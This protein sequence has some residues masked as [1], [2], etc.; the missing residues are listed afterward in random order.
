MI[1]CFGMKR[2]Y[3]LFSFLVGMITIGYFD[4]WQGMILSAV[5]FMIPIVHRI[6]KKQMAALILLFILG[7]GYF[8]LYNHII[9]N[10]TEN[11][12][13]NSKNTVLKV[14]SQPEE[15]S[16]G[17]TSYTCKMVGKPFKIKLYIRGKVS[18]ISYF[19]TVNVENFT[20]YSA[21]QD[22]YSEYLKSNSVYGNIT[23]DRQQ[24]SIIK[25]AH[26]WN[27]QV[28]FFRWKAHLL[29]VLKTHFSGD[30]YQL[31]SGIL[32]GDKSEQTDSFQHM[33]SASGVS[34]VVV[35]SGLHFGLWILMLSR[36]LLRLRLSLQK[37]SV[38]LIV[39]TLF[40]ALFMGW[41][42]SIIRVSVMLII[43]YLCDIYL[44]NH[45]DKIVI[46]ILAAFVP[47]ICNPNI[48]FS[49]SFIL[50]YGAVLGILLFSDKIAEILKKIKISFPSVNG[51]ISASISAQ[52][53]VFPFLI[54]YFN[55]FS[56]VFI[57][58]NLLLCL[59]LPFFMGYGIVFLF[60]TMIFPALGMVL[61]YP[62]NGILSVLVWG[63]QWI[64]SLPFAEISVYGA[65]KYFILFYLVLLYLFCKLRYR[66][67]MLVIPGFAVLFLSLFFSVIN[68]LGNGT[69]LVCLNL[70]DNTTY[71]F[72]TGQ[73]HTVLL[74]LAS[75][76]ER[77][78]YTD[79]T[80]VDAI[81]SHAGGNIDYYIAGGK[82]Q[83]ESYQAIKENI[84]VEH[85]I[86][87]QALYPLGG[88]NAQYLKEDATI[89]LDGLQIELLCQEKDGLITTAVVDYYD[90][91]IL[92]S[93]KLNEKRYTPLKQE[94]Y[95]IVMINRYISTVS[96]KVS[97]SVSEWNAEK[98]IYN[99]REKNTNS[100][101]YNMNFYDKIK[102][103]LF[104]TRNFVI[105]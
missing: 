6:S 94:D 49:V 34:H 89:E 3:Y 12:G 11:F 46:V 43:N 105:K 4:I 71:L 30:A 51:I 20:Y 61:S 95:D 99:L 72:R 24:L 45:D 82:M 33:M 104:P 92:A 58:G 38:I 31:I 91:H 84:G 56:L 103:K 42:P 1:G 93:S 64:S 55:Q 19:D 8:T 39:A 52:I 29:S 54:Y 2:I 62:L 27:P 7:C 73:N 59:L 13:E 25:K 76:W 96:Q 70:A 28:V 35:V 60:I 18:D 5:L 90:N 21:K 78:E 100:D 69:D 41:T 10:A 97:G 86:I 87:P 77:T 68:Y 81:R 98:V 50:S 44:M 23:I 80:L 14:V 57:L 79:K 16:G 32:L 74:D 102:I 101:C 37:R 53:L 83:A 88:E 40:F 15:T 22:S 66:K 63:L 67:K 85:V 75:D 9:Q 36:I 26:P 47:V 65:D 48:I 17:N